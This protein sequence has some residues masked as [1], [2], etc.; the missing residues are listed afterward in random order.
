MTWRPSHP[1][2][3]F[4]HLLTATLAAVVL[5]TVGCGPSVDVKPFSPAE[6]ARVQNETAAVEQRGYRV[7]PYDTLLI[8]YPFHPEMDQE[9][10]VRPDGTI[11]AT[12]V[13]QVHVSGMTAPDVANHL[14]QQ[15]SRRLKNPEVVVSISKYGERGIFVGGEVGRPQMLV[16]RKGLTP[17]QAIMAAGGFLPTARLDSVIL[18]R[19]TGGP[20]PFLARKLDLKSAML[21]GKAEPIPLMPQ[22]V[23]FVPRTPIANANVWVRQHVTDLFPFLRIPIPP[24]L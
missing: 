11:S 5:A 17:L 7:E 4:W 2:R 23:V 10:V 16:F 15:S 19:H 24:M 14:K 22:D 9:T 8:K 21:K 12:G 20:E 3:R 18:V 6:L 1:S 13:G